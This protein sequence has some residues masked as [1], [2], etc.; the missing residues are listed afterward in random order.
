MPAAVLVPAA[1]LARL[2]AGAAWRGLDTSSPASTWPSP[3]ICW[4]L[5]ITASRS[6]ASRGLGGAGAGACL[7]FRTAAS[8]R[9][10]AQFEGR[11]RGPS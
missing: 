10:S 4:E 11:T 6:N 5:L 8:E 9:C 3:R 1:S 7:R 2:A